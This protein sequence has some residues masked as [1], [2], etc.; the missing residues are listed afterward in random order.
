[1]EREGEQF[2]CHWS[3]LTELSVAHGRGEVTLAA[4]GER[5][6]FTVGGLHAE[7]LLSALRRYQAASHRGFESAGDVP[8]PDSALSL[9]TDFKPGDDGRGISRV[10]P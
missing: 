4:H 8:P 7:R 2:R 5:I 10:A 3:E 9:V 6:T 1:V